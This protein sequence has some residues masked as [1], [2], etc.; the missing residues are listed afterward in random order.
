MQ[1]IPIP[2]SFKP[3]TILNLR[4]EFENIIARFYRQVGSK[5]SLVIADLEYLL[6]HGNT[7]PSETRIEIRMLLAEAR[8]SIAIMER[9]QIMADA[10]IRHQRQTPTDDDLVT[11][12][13]RLWRWYGLAMHRDAENSPDRI[14]LHDW[15]ARRKSSAS[16]A[17]K[18]E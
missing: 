8:A 2:E 10:W 4:A 11:L 18:I 16:F 15:R 1:Q 13:I 7:L 3:A 6:S 12:I 9:R 5:L 17:L 14:M